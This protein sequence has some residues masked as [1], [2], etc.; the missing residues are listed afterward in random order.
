[1]QLETDLPDD[2]AAR[3]ARATVISLPYNL[4]VSQAMQ[5]GYRYAA[6][7]CDC[8]ARVDGDG[9][10]DAACIAQLLRPIRDGKAD[11]AVG[12]RFAAVGGYV[13]SAAR[14]IGIRFFSALVCLVTGRH[15]SDTTSGFHAC[16][17]DVALFL[18]HNMPGDY[19]EIEGADLLLVLCQDAADGYMDLLRPSGILIYEPDDVVAPPSFKGPTFGIPFNRLYSGVTGQSE[20]AS[21][22]L[23]LGAVAAITGV[24]SPVSLRKA[25]LSTVGTGVGPPSPI[26]QTP[27]YA[28]SCVAFFARSL[29]R[30]KT[31]CTCAS[32]AFFDFAFI[33]PARNASLI[34]APVYSPGQSFWR[35]R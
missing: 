18:A 13:P 30:F 8:L 34:S 14:A 27:S 4:G 15:F 25:V 23:T 17:R 2:P 32:R 28:G 22:V 24:V 21:E 6:Q 16:T 11:F 20:T 7:T 35:S 5:V 1:M 29:S 10:H 33:P 31:E 12:S 9:Q 3:Q 19:P 26:C